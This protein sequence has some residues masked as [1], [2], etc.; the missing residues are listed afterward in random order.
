MQTQ[1][2]YENSL[3]V[4]TVAAAANRGA[5]LFGLGRSGLE[6][7]RPSY[8]ILHAHFLMQTYLN[9]RKVLF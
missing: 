3:R 7:F 1:L 2:P 6:T 9:Q 4:F 5:R 8:E